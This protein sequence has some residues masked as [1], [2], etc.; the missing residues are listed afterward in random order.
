[1][2]LALLVLLLSSCA[3]AP[4]LT[5]PPLEPPL[6]AAF[7]DTPDGV[8]LYTSISGD[9]SRG[10]VWFVMGPELPSAPPYPRLTQAL[11]AAGFATAV[12][13]ARGTGFSDGPRG[14]LADYSLFLKDLRQGLEFLKQ[15]FPARPVVLFG[16][17]AGAALA[18]ELA[19]GRSLPAVLVNPAWKMKY[20]EGMGPT[21][22]DYVTYAA[23]LVFRPTALTVD[24][25]RNPSAISFEAD[26]LEAEA[27]QADAVVVRFFSM[28]FLLAQA[29]VMDRCLENAKR[30]DA[31]V[32]VV[33][34]TH[35][36]LVDP[37][38][39]QELFDA[40]PSGKQ[41]LVAPEGGHGSSAV[42]TQV[43]A[44]VEWLERTVAP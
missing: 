43:E 42:E 37:A 32:L 33:E 25:N 10:V 9:G 5:R 24:M 2:R 39:T 16:Q 23:N 26:R 44:I 18:L 7:I 20:G 4:L 36:V 22:G 12:V 15:R 31:P 38:G 34:G 6:G 40:I 19:A 14:D 29:K 27:M 3:A 11:H 13:H 30:L 1:M 21:F 8:R 35:D 17:S 28:R 41:R